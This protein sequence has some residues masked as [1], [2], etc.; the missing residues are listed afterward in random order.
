MIASLIGDNVA[1][2]TAGKQ[3]SFNYYLFI[4]LFLIDE[5]ARSV[6]ESMLHVAKQK[7][8]VEKDVRSK[9]KD[10]TIPDSPP[11]PTG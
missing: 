4:Y 8:L 6:E 11:A 7:G 10:E 1:P 3:I 9:E 2:T 5:L